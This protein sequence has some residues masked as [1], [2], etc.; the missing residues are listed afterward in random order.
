METSLLRIEEFSVGIQTHMGSMYD[1]MNQWTNGSFKSY[2]KAQA[3][4]ISR[5]EYHSCKK[6][7][8]QNQSALEHDLFGGFLERVGVKFDCLKILTY[9]K[10]MTSLEHV[11]EIYDHVKD[12]AKH[13]HGMW[14]FHHRHPPSL[15]FLSNLHLLHC[16]GFLGMKVGK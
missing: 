5:Q 14:Q 16:V 13:R 8:C 4:W 11:F 10:R 1:K 6:A 2:T 9:S 12:N 3:N 7:T 15:T